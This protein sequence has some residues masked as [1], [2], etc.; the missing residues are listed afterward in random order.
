[1]NTSIKNIIT[2]TSFCLF[3]LLLFYGLYTTIKSFSHY[4]KN[5]QSITNT[6][7]SGIIALGT[8]ELSLERSLSQLSLNLN[9]PVS[10]N[11]RNMI[12]KQREL[13]TP[14]F[15][16]VVKFVTENDSLSSKEDF[17]SKLTDKIQR[18]ESLRKQVDQNLNLPLPERDSNF[19]SDFPVMFPELVEEIQFQGRILSL[20]SQINYS[21]ILLHQE[22]QNESWLFREFS[23]RERTL[24]AILVARQEI[25]SEDKSAR[26]TLLRSRADSALKKLKLLSLN[27]N[28]EP[29]I[30]TNIETLE[31]EYEI[32]Y[33]RLRDQVLYSA[34]DS[35][36]AIDLN[37]FFKQSSIH[38]HKSEDL[39]K[40]TNS[41]I[42]KLLIS[43]KN[44]NLLE[45]I[46]TLFL[47]L[48]GIVV[49]YFSHKYL[50][51]T[52]IEP[53]SQLTDLLVRLSKGDKNINFGIFKNK[54]NE[55]G[56][57]VHSAEVFRE[58]MLK[59]DQ[60]ITEQSSA[61]NETTT[62]ME[63]LD[64]SSKK[65]AEQAQVAASNAK[66]A[67][68]TTIAGEEVVSKMKNLMLDMKTKVTEITDQISLLNEQTNQIGDISHLVSELAKQTNMLA[69]N[70]AIEASRAGEHGRGFAVV[71]SE[72]RKLADESKN[73]AEK[74]QDI[75]EE[76]KKSVSTSST[77]SKK[78][79]SAAEEG[80]IYAEDTS[81]SFESV[82][83]SISSASESIQQIAFNLK[84]QSVA[85]HE[86]LQAMSSL[87]ERSSKVSNDTKARLYS[88]N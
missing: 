39:V 50:S 64:I 12:D 52:V 56:K 48:F 73:S 87:N 17:T 54:E 74:I 59:I 34:K 85:F 67:L 46:F 33:S 49:V 21:D 4:L 41:I 35:K 71:A 24:L 7:N 88:L 68:E 32:D 79:T 20:D 60:L 70:A 26:I 81:K 86:V 31:K 72:I 23:G 82:S 80:V 77:L 69:L 16:Q 40:Q 8:I 65:S 18:L 37:E 2:I 1:M 58:N 42:K 47:L 76:I 61:V 51:T 78:G 36:Y 29:E 44:Y 10:T 27:P 5:K 66:D 30:K 43:K 75:V 38:L 19:V 9:D 63:K 55:V 6:E 53:I 28:I 13:S 15:K 45:F 62:T 22:V 11:F 14:N 84:Q 25:I 83:N 3:S 57:M